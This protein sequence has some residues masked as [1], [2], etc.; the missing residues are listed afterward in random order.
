MKSFK[1]NHDSVESLSLISA[2]RKLAKAILAIGNFKIEIMKNEFVSLVNFIIGQQLSEK[3]ANTI[4]QRLFSSVDVISPE[5]LINTNDNIFK[6]AGI[7]KMKTTF[8][9][10]LSLKIINNEIDFKQLKKADDDLVIK[11]LTEIKGIGQWTAEMFL[12]FTLGRKDVMSLNDVG[13]QR[14]IKWL[15]RLDE[16]PDKEMLIKISN[17]WKPY[18]SFASLYLWELIN[19]NM[20]S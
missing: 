19:R 6:N 15:Y 2:D 3:A 17:K 12:I 16:T 4:Y 7:S 10:D 13:L 5:I 1:L 20:L 11:K 8:I 14:S 9:K 18:R